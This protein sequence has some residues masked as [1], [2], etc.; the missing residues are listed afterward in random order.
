MLPRI[1]LHFIFSPASLSERLRER[2]DAHGGDA[3]VSSGEVK[4]EKT[5]FSSE[6]GRGSAFSPLRRQRW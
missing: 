4:S 5:G 1:I 3:Y 6:G 2:K